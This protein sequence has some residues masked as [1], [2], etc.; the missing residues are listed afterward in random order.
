[1]A[2]GTEREALDR[3]E[4]PLYAQQARLILQMQERELE[5]RAAL[6]GMRT[7]PITDAQVEAAATVAADARWLPHGGFGDREMTRAMLE[8]ARD[9]S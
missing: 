3:L 1:M 5:L 6:A 2:N 9:A 4:E 7:A 8:A